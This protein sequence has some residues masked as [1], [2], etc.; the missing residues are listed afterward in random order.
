MTRKPLPHS[1]QGTNDGRRY[2]ETRGA[3]K[4]EIDVDRDRDP[5]LPRWAERPRAVCTAAEAELD[6]AGIDAKKALEET[7]DNGGRLPTR[8]LAEI[9]KPRGLLHPLY[10]AA[11]FFANYWTLQVHIQAIAA[12]K[13]TT[14]G[15]ENAALRFADAYYQW[16]YELDAHDDVYSAKVAA[17][18]RAKGRLAPKDKVRRQIEELIGAA[19]LDS[20]KSAAQLANKHFSRVCALLEIRRMR[21]PKSPYAL[22]STIQRIRALRSTGEIA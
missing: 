14:E 5:D 12:G 4:I 13:A 3:L 19:D 7:L 16:A 17:A 21:P 1:K 18:N 22:A 8:W 6:K 11:Y 10:F 15:L 2:R 20:K 9:A